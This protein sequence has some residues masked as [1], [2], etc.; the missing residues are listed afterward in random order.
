MRSTMGTLPTGS[1]GLGTLRVSGRSRVPNPPTRMTASTAG[2]PLSRGGCAD[3]GRGF[4]RDGGRRLACDGRGG[5]T[6][7]GGRRLAC[8]GRRGRSTRIDRTEFGLT[9]NQTLETG[10]L[11]VGKQVDI[12]LE[13]EAVRPLGEEA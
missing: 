5:V 8:N 4:T 9:W 13:V 7:D 10:G 6:G 3:R 2:L 12:T 1:N 11:V